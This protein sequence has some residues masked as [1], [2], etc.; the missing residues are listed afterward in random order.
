MHWPGQLHRE[1]ERSKAM[2]TRIKLFVLLVLLLLTPVSGFPASDRVSWIPWRVDLQPPIETVLT[3]DGQPG[4]NRTTT[5]TAQITPDVDVD[6]LTLHWVLPPGVTLS[7]SITE[8][9]GTVSAGQ[10]AKSQRDLAFDQAGTFKVAVSAQASTSDPPAIWS[11]AD[12]LFFS[13]HPGWGSHVSRRSPETPSTQVRVDTPNVRYSTIR[14]SAS[15]QGSYQVT[16]RVMFEDIPM[17]PGACPQPAQLVPARQVLVEIWE[18]D[19]GLPDD[20]DGTTRT[21][22][23]GYFSWQVPDNDD[24]LTDT[25]GKETYLRIF[26]DTP[27]GYVTDRGIVDD[28][29]YIE[30]GIHQ[31]GQN[32][33]FGTIEASTLSP[34]FNISDA[35]LDGYRY[36]SQFRDPPTRVKVRYEPG[37]ESQS[38]YNMV[39]ERINL[40]GKADDPDAYDDS[41]ILHEYGHFIA[42]KYACDD[43]FGGEHNWY[44]HYSKRLAWSEGWANYLPSAVRSTSHYFDMN[45]AGSCT[46]IDWE[47][48]TVTGSTNEGAV[49]ATLWD[50]HDTITETHDRLSLGGEYIWLTFQNWMGDSVPVSWTDCNVDAFWDGWLEAGYPD[51]SELAAIFA[52]HHTAGLYTT[53]Q[54]NQHVVAASPSPTDIPTARLIRPA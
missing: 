51:D 23:N 25:D 31:G 37:K 43:S 17:A 49:C 33:D 40:C 50:I 52:H 28:R 18:E 44:K 11:D 15:P 6:H 14:Q 38:H 20:H 54:T 27:G 41:V 2:S 10:T 19:K 24:G 1:K 13:I 5:L 53:T 34:M 7:G 22:D 30:T 32:I 42:D 35:L 8:S 3:W 4:L 48:W 29:Y 36:I 45:G 12:V 46:D 47:T 39:V 21:D 26:P 9:L 16:G